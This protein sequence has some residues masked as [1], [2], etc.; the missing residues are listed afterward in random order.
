MSSELEK[1]YKRAKYQNANIVLDENTMSMFSFKIKLR[2]FLIQNSG[3]LI[4]Y[5]LM[6]IIGLYANKMSFL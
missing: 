6:L 2:N 5:F 1:S 3:I 4:G